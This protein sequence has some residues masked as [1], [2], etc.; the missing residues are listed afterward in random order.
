VSDVVNTLVVSGYSR[1]QERQADEAAIVILSRVGYNPSALVEMLTVMKS[2]LKAGG[3]GFAKTHPNPQD[4][5]N[6]IQALVG[7]P[8][9]ATPPPARQARFE[10]ALGTV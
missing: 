3:P 7:S 10:R 4:R 1:D 6:A 5:I 9:K 8:G 2:Q